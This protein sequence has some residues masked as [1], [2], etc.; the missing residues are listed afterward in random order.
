MEPKGRVVG[1][2][3]EHTVIFYGLSTCIWCRKARQHL[4]ALGVSFDYYYVDLL[5]GAERERIVE[6]VRCWNPS[7]SFPTLVVDDRRAIIGFRPE[8]IQEALDL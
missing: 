4:E 8:E 1:P 7:V 6:Q 5:Q 2:H 3:N